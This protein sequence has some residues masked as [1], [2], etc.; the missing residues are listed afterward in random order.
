MMGRLV[1]DPE[2][3]YS[4]GNN[5]ELAIANF[6]I[7]VD[8]KFKKNDEENVD[9]FSCSAFGRLAE[10]V[11]QYLTQGIKI[12]ISGRMQTENY[13]NR[14]GDKVYG[15]KLIAEDIDF[16]ESKRASEEYQDEEYE[17]GRRRGGSS[18]NRQSSSSNRRNSSG[19]GSSRNTSRRGDEERRESGRQQKPSGRSSSGSNGGGSRRYQDPDR[20]FER[21]DERGYDGYNDGEFD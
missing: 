15:V 9:F 1:R 8:R 20:E 16:A 6:R 7:A 21:T 17:E 18:K 13:T 14:D 2:I 3:R 5:G 10:F 12:V 19:S 4:Q 11:E